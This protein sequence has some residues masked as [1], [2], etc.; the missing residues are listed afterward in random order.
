LTGVQGRFRANNYN[1]G[2]FI[3]YEPGLAQW[4]MS[5]SNSKRGW[6]TCSY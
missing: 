4:E 3:N 2:V 5:V 6:S 1:D